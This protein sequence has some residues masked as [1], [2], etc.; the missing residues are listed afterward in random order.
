M[1]AAVLAELHDLDQGLARVATSQGVA[2]VDEQDGPNPDA[3]FLGECEGA[4][5]RL[6]DRGF[7]SVLGAVVGVA[8]LDVVLIAKIQ[9]EPA[10]YRPADENGIARL[11]ETEGKKGV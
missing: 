8:D 5:K 2:R 10:V 11:S 6:D 9:L 4:L 7:E 1:E 3:L